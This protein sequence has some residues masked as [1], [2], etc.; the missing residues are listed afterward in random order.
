MAP[1]ISDPKELE[2]E[3]HRNGS[4]NDGSR[5]AKEREAQKCL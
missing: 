2:R 3:K 1:R 4:E 5:G